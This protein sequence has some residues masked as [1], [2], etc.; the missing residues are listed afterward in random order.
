MGAGEGG[1][2][3]PQRAGHSGG[4]PLGLGDTGELN[5]PGAPPVLLAKS[6]GRVQR[7]SGLAD[8]ARAYQSHQPAGTNRQPQL[9]ELRIAAYEAAQRVPQVARSPRRWDRQ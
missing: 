7:Q 6:G 2:G 4:N 3:R 5:Q 9:F 1:C 8:P